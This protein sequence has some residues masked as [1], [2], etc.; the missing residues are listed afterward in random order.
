LYGGFVEG[1]L[2]LWVV[3]ISVIVRTESSYGGKV[4]IVGGDNI[5]N[6]RTEISYGGK[7]IIVGGDNFGHCE[8]RKII[9]S[10]G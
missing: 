6:L 3:I 5:G 2:I 8:K 4:N 1:R 10:E 7:V 9:W